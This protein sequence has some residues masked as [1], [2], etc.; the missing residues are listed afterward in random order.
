[1]A[2]DDGEKVFVV[3]AWKDSG[4]SGEWETFEIPRGQSY[5][6]TL[7]E[8]MGE[9]PEFISADIGMKCPDQEKPGLLGTH[10]DGQMTMHV[11]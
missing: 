10:C 2:T 5:P 6:D 9:H 4:R 7:K 3:H 8:F 11:C 1:M